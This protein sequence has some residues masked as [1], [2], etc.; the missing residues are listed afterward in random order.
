[1]KFIPYDSFQIETTLDAAEVERLLAA[2]TEAPKRWYLTMA[3]PDFF[4]K[5][6]I[7]NGKFEVERNTNY[8]KNS[9]APAISGVIENT[10]DQTVIKLKLFPKQQTIWFI[11]LFL[12]GTFAG[13]SIFIISEIRTYAFVWD[14]L[15]AY[16]PFL[17]GY[18]LMMVSFNFERMWANKFIIKL[19][20][21][22]E[23]ILAN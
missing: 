17:F 7:S 6:Y 19:M 5:G 22:Q 11:S 15:R 21:A 9:F 14:D 23:T 3:E 13:A 1:M 18:L 2:N 16:L 4:F 10:G 12:L 20:V 8:R